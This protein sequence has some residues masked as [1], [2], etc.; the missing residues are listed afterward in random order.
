MTVWILGANGFD[1]FVHEAVGGTVNALGG[2]DEGFLRRDTEGGQDRADDLR[3]QRQNDGVAG[4]ENRFL[5]TPDR[6]VVTAFPG[7][8]RKGRAPGTVTQHR[9]IAHAFAPR[10]PEP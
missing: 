4:G 2:D 10:R 7:Q 1:H 9:D 3:W 8:G 5:P 6:N